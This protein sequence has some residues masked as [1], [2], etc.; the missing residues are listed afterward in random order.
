M[1]YWKKL[2][3]R[4]SKGAHLDHKPGS[5]EASRWEGDGPPLTAQPGEE[6]AGKKVRKLAA[7]KTNGRSDCAC[8]VCG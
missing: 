8:V 6:T 2:R 7:R 3:T 4:R 5:P 1:G